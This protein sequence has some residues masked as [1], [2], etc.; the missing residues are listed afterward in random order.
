MGRKR[1]TRI[2][3]TR[4][5][6]SLVAS[7]LIGLTFLVSGTG[8]IFASGAVPAQVVDF[9]SN[10]IPDIFITPATVH[11]LY[12]VFIPRIV[13]W[14][15][16]IFGVCLLI[17]FLPRLMAILTIP[18]LS[19]FLGT[20]LWSMIQGGYTT[21][22]SCFGI[23]ERF[24]GSLTPVQSLIYDLALFVFVT[25]IIV[26]HPGGFFTSRQWLANLGKRQKLD[27]TT[28]KSKKLGLGS[29]LRN[30]G[31]KAMAGLR[32]IRENARQHPRI[33]SI[34]GICLLGLITYG[35]V[36]AFTGATVPQ[37]GT[38]E[39]IPVISDVYTEVS[40]VSAVISWMTDKPTISSVQ[41]HTKDGT[42]VITVTDKEL[43]TTHRIL[44]GGLSSGTTYYFKVLLDDKLALTAENSFT[45][46]AA[47]P[48]PFMISYVKVS[49]VTETSAT[50]TWLTNRPAT[51]GVEYWGAGTTDKLTVSKG[52]LTTAH[53]IN[54]VGL[55]ADV[56]YHYQVKSTDASGNQVVS[57]LF[58]MSVQIGKRAP[59]FTLNSL[60]GK[61]I[62][63]GDYRGKVVMLDFW[64]SSCSACR[65]KMS[66]IQEAFTRMPADK[67]AILSI[68][69]KGKESIIQSYV[70]G[71]GLTVPILLD[72]E[73][74]VSDLY[75]VTALPTTFFIDG[76]G[77]IRLIDPEF[78][79]AEELENIFKAILGG[80]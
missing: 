26:F 25:L 48:S 3:K 36:A 32:L 76:D 60:D 4:D 55:E 13:P 2:R 1:P 74:A 38:K 30:L 19:A 72:L 12:E 59:D 21:C 79:N 53:S 50:I 77:I 68:H 18:L 33:A 78:G 28:L 15:E 34:V 14:A 5:R 66:I 11:F 65:Q 6:I 16:F 49:F 22:A 23:W 42:F 31:S 20:N 46:L 45:T 8:K 37:N 47:A 40:E 51:S 61:A 24:F 75:K 80:T 35:I 41:V 70:I 58:T 73:G 17:G 43:V 44:A 10:S 27:A 64:M 9:I 7:I 52:E 54:L 56:I 71:E 63:L 39:E 69:F 29:R 67:I 57:P 62:T